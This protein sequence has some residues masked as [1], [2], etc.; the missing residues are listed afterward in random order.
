M[1]LDVIMQ[2]SKRDYSI[3]TT[4]KHVCEDCA[5][6]CC[7]CDD[8]N[9]TTRHVEPSDCHACDERQNLLCRKRNFIKDV[10]YG[11]ITAKSL[12]KLTVKNL[13]II[14]K[15]FG[16]NITGITIKCDIIESL[17]DYAQMSSFE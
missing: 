13:R 11:E 16:V 12:K 14:A 6:H 5:Y 8:E 4:N 9:E 15:D 2:R 1:K 17:I 10:Q 3:I 7:G